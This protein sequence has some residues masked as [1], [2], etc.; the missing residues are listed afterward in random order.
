[1]EGVGEASDLGLADG[2]VGHLGAF[3]ESQD[4]LYLGVHGREK[5]SSELGLVVVVK[6]CGW[7]N[8]FDTFE[9]IVEEG[10]GP[11][12]RG[13]GQPPDGDGVAP[14]RFAMVSHDSAQIVKDQ[15]LSPAL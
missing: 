9:K 1:M 13:V 5:A 14:V 15:L 12:R 10:P 3:G 7:L 2:P 4:L 8:D 6:L 11:V